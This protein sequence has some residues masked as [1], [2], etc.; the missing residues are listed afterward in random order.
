MPQRPV[1]GVV[2]DFFPPVLAHEPVGAIREFHPL[3]QCGAL[4]VFAEGGFLDGGWGDVVDSAGDEQQL[5]RWGLRL[6]AQAG[7]H[8]QLAKSAGVFSDVTFDYDGQWRVRSGIFVGNTG[9]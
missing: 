9:R 1:Q 8:I 7:A 5:R 6:G 3:D 4:C 2:G